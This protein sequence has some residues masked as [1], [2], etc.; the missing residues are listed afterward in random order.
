MS[1]IKFLKCYT[2]MNFYLEKQ[3]VTLDQLCCQISLLLLH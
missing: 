3:E 2:L 1:V